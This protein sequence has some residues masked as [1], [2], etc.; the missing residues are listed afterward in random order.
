MTDSYP[1]ALDDVLR[2]AHERDY[3]GYSKFDA[4]NSPLLRAATLGIGPL[5]WACSQAVY[6]FP[7]NLRPLLGVRTGRNPK[8]IGLFALAYLYRSR[9]VSESA[10]E[11]IERA[12]ELLDW[13]A[14]HPSTGYH[15]ACWGYNHP[16]P[17][18]RF[19]VPSYTPNLVVTGNVVIALLEGY[20]QLGDRRY[21]ELARS[22]LEFILRDLNTLIDTP[23]D[24]AIS[25]VPG[26]Q[27][28]VLNN[29]GLA[30]VLMAWCAKLTG[31]AQLREMAR[32]HIHFLAAQQTDEG[33]WFY[34]YPP[35]SSPVTHDNYHTGNVLDWLLLYEQLTGDDSF[36]APFVRGL[37]FYRDRLFLDD[38]APKHRHNRVYPHDIHGSAQG[39]I[40]FARAAMHGL[41][42]FLSLGETTLQWAMKHLRAPDGHYY[43][44]RG[45]FHTNRTSLMRWNQS[46]MALALAFFML[47]RSQSSEPTANPTSSR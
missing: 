27:W 9:V 45:R 23:E 30:A 3:A 35:K 21:L 41:P 12:R 10:K 17:N 11:S 46:W 2:Y 38:G 40:T 8:G 15:G 37:K 34:A 19:S 28:I 13:L 32:R 1:Q 20:E 44:Q 26:S 14:E 43:Y 16:W 29:Q 25:Y 39:T 4:L 7:I 5:Q 18:F 31:E 47:A 24:R 33:A 6:R 42:E 22:S 36:H